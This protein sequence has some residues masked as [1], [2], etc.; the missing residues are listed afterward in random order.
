MRE[1]GEGGTP[2][3]L[4][5]VRSEE[6]YRG[7]SCPGKGKAKGTPACP[8]SQ[9]ETEDP[10]GSAAFPDTWP[11]AGQQ[12]PALLVK[13]RLPAAEETQQL[14]GA[15]APSAWEAEEEGLSALCC[16]TCSGRSRME[17]LGSHQGR[18]RPGALCPR[19][20]CVSRTAARSSGP[21][22]GLK[23]APS[24]AEAGLG[25]LITKGVS[26]RRGSLPVLQQ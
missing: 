25:R 9:E 22:P 7:S 14:L 2:K 23:A 26:H 11:R 1:F 19:G 13:L 17:S 15:W 12:G 16:H 21:G 3:F 20:T 4:R 18:R 24:T 5:S 8:G 10:E 6:D